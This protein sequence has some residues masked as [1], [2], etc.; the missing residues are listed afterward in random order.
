[1]ELDELR[2]HVGSGPSDDVLER[3]LNA[4]LESI[5]ARYGPA[6]EETSEQRV[7]P[8]GSLVY[9]SRRAQSI[10][11]VYENTELVAEENYE[12]TAGGKAIRRLNDDGD[13][14]DWLATVDVV[15]APYTDNAD[16][17]RV[18]VA[19]V[20]LDLNA[21]PGMSSATV[22]SW[23]EQYANN[24]V[25]NYRKERE[26]ILASLRPATVGVW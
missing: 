5:V 19:L 22:G 25:W 4:A 17:D 21:A 16:R 12:L 9:L 2:E 8:S 11:S 15:Y 20:K 7:D 18:T 10:T 24:S 13:P 6:E 26:G 3:L 14:T 23:S 1:M